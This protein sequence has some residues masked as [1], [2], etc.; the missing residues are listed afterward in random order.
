M[1]FADRR[2]AGRQLGSALAAH[3]L[4]D[5]L[6]VALPRGGVPIAFARYRG[7]AAP[8][9]VRG[10][11]VVLVDDGIATGVTDAVAAR[12]L[13]EMG[14]ARIVLAVP[15][16]PGES[17][18]RLAAEVDE[19]VCLQRPRPFLGV[20]RW[21]DDF[22]PTSDEEVL[23]LLAA[24][25]RAARAP[26]RARVAA[27]RPPDAGG[28]GGADERLRRRAAR[29]PPRRRCAVGRRGAGSPA[30]RSASSAPR[31][32]RPQPCAPRRRSTGRPPRSSRAADGP[33]SPASGSR[34]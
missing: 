9:D 16:G 32:A 29:R 12:A 19:V 17:L 33:T 3:R 18:D 34:M 22:A 23:E 20:G 6:V 21:Y 5:P 25:Q 27:V 26:P 31:R 28:G 2:D 7:G 11:L 1:I 10:R 8:A 14:A 24:T 15:V 30:S 4:P 13:R